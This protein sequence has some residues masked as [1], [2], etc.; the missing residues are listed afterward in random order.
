M[1]SFALGPVKN[2]VKDSTAIGIG[3]WDN[4]DFIRKVTRL[5]AKTLNFSFFIQTNL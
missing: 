2:V 1:L 5:D 3:V 4:M